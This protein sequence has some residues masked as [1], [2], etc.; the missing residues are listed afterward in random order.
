MKATKKRNRMIAFSLAVVF[1]LLQVLSS[2]G[3]LSWNRV[4]KVHAAGGP[5]DTTLLQVLNASGA[6]IA[7]DPVMAVPEVTVTA[8]TTNTIDLQWTAVANASSYYIFKYDEI[9][10]QY[11]CIAATQGVSYQFAWLPDGEEH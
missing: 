3:A 11:L 4:M 8:T 1:C 9:T 6:A 2:T 7:I 5:E 10:D